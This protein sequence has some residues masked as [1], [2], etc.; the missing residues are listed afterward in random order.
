MRYQDLLN[1]YMLAI[2]SSLIQE[3][4]NSIGKAGYTGIYMLNNLQ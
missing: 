2:S 1:G 3:V 4:G